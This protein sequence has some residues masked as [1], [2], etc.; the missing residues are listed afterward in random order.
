MKE[1]LKKSDM[2]IF[3]SFKYLKSL[4]EKKD[5]F[6]LVSIAVLLTILWGYKINLSQ[7]LWSD[8]LPYAAWFNDRTLF[9]NDLFAACFSFIPTVFYPVFSLVSRSLGTLNALIIFLF[10]QNMAIVFATYYLAKVL[11]REKKT[12]Y[13]SI[14]WVVL[15]GG[16]RYGLGAISPA[17]ISIIPSLLA[18]PLLLLAISFYLENHFFLLFLTLAFSAYLH[19]SLTFLTGVIIFFSFL[20]LTRKID[21]WKKL[22]P[23]FLVALILT[24]PLFFWVINLHY[25]PG[26]DLPFEQWMNLMRLRS[27]WH[28]FPSKFGYSQWIPFLFLLALWTFFLKIKMKSVYEKK[29]IFLCMSIFLL[30]FL[31]TIFTEIFPTR[32]V[33]AIIPFRVTFIFVVIVF[34]YLSNFLIKIFEKKKKTLF[35]LI[36]LTGFLLIFLPLLVVRINT[37]PALRFFD[38]NNFPKVSVY[39]FVERQRDK[40]WLDVQYWVSKNTPKEKLIIVPPYLRE[41][42]AYSERGIVLSW[43]DAIYPIYYPHT[44]KEVMRRLT[45][46]GID[47]ANFRDNTEADNALKNSFLKFTEKDFT[48]IAE[49]YDV[50]FAVVEKTKT[51]LFPE[52]YHNESFRVYQIKPD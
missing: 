9:S 16:L 1:K 35:D 22:F 34:I 29:I 2:P 31:G 49:K 15:A 4:I 28:S 7:S 33:I 6:L 8:A 18:I 42:R 26:G 30:F 23:G 46:Y 52:F 27:S 19:L 38:F 3:P 24:L 51:L 11:F 50:S 39:S 10:F 13:L 44:G 45:D 48:R 21:E 25:S 40:D 37:I 32:L 14:L 17:G 41:F 43:E 12:A 5:T 20:L 36:F 47:P